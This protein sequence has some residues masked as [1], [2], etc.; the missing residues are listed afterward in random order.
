[1]VLSNGEKQMLFGTH[2]EALDALD[3]EIKKTTL[4]SARNVVDMSESYRMAKLEVRHQG[5]PGVLFAVSD[6]YLRPFYGE[7]AVPLVKFVGEWYKNVQGKYEQKEDG[8]QMPS[9][10]FSQSSE[11]ECMN[12]YDNIIFHTPGG[13]VSADRNDLSNNVK[14]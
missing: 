9:L 10:F 5:M 7:N 1:M 3:E 14:V 6:Y 2:D 12:Y 4:P 8:E 11:Y 13:F